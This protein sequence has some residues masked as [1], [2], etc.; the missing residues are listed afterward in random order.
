MASASRV[1]AVRAAFRTLIRAQRVA[2]ANDELAQR[3]ALREIRSGFEKSRHVADV[4]VVDRLLA[5][6]NEAADFI[7]TQ[8]V[9]V[10]MNERGNFEM[11]VDGTG[12][13]GAVVAEPITPSLVKAISSEVEK[14]N[15]P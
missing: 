7:R 12:K 4:Q 1:T 2:F 3:L 14:E 13:G 15:Q 5:E 6:A 11:D 9:Q 10:K 8:L